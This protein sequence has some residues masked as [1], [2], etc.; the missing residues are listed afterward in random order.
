[1]CLLLQFAASK[2]Q[3]AADWRSNASLWTPSG[4]FIF[5]GLKDARA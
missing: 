3:P 1:M 2:T 5:Q 4:G